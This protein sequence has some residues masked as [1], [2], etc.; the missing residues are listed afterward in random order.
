M[1]NRNIASVLVDTLA[2]HPVVLLQGARQVGKSTLALSLANGPYKARYLTLDEAS[3][4]TAARTDPAAF[5]GGLDGPVVIDEVQRAP[6]LLLAIKMAVDKERRPGQFLLMGSANVLLLPRLADTLAGR[7]GILTLWPFSQ[8][9]REGVRERFVDAL[10]QESLSPPLSQRESWPQL[11]ER[12]VRGG[13]PEAVA[14]EIEGRRHGWFGS[15]IT[16]ILQRDVRDIAAIDDLTVMPRLLSLLAARAS[17]LLNISELSRSAGIPL[18]TLRRYLALLE[19]AFLIQVVPAWSANLGKRLVRAPKIFLSD[20]GLMTYLLGISKEQV[21]QNGTMK[22]PLLENL[23]VMELKKQITWSKT[24][25]ALFHFRAVSGQEV[26]IVLESRAGAL[27]GIE[28]K[29]TSTLTEKDFRPLRFFAETAGKR[30]H[31]GVLLYTGAETISFGPRLHAL[32]ISALWKT[33]YQ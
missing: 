11:F 22:G 5:I 6:E 23:V 9:E 17:S 15:Y 20:S 21:E 33:A 25:P 26:D 2:T 10:F 32:P 16:T 13:Y 29:A 7:M 14:Q 28:V 18:T 19:M 30:F 24:L 12:M 31:R 4:L 1:I 3:V 27:V 8:G